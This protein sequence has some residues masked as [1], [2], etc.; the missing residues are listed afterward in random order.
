MLHTC[1]GS[2]QGPAPTHPAN[3]SEEFGWTGDGWERFGERE[4]VGEDCKKSD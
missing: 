4:R 3:I 2:D 1:T